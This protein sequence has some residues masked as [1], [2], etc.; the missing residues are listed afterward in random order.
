MENQEENNNLQKLKKAPA[1]KYDVLVI[2]DQILN[3]MDALSGIMS[4]KEANWIYDNLKKI[5]YVSNENLKDLDQSLEV[6]NDL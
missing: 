2:A 5:D 6:E 1:S 4:T 3:V